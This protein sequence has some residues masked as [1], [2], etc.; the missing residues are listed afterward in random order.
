MSNYYSKGPSGEWL[1]VVPSGGKPNAKIDV[2]KKNGEVQKVKLL[3]EECV[4][5]GKPAFSFEALDGKGKKKLASDAQRRAMRN[6]AGRIYMI[7]QFDSISQSPAEYASELEKA[8]ENPN[9]SSKE[10]SDYIDSASFAIED[11]M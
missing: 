5:W 2:S 7:Q 10:A 3:V 9:L 6:M 1:V 11:E 8:A 4:I